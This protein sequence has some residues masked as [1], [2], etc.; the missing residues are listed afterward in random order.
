MGGGGVYR[1]CR[2]LLDLKAMWPIVG[3]KKRHCFAD[4]AECEQKMVTSEL[5]RQVK[6]R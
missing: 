2:K 3:R 6:T 1:S 5:I 4:N